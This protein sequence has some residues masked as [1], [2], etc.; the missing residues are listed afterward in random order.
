MAR[1]AENRAR[2]AGGLTALGY[3]MPQGQTP[4]LP[5]LVGGAD[6]AVALSKNLLE[7]GVLAPAVR[8]PTVP[9]GTSRLRLTVMATHT[10]GQI[11]QALAAIEAC[12]G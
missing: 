9:E 7:R 5:V 6:D 8:P 3:G 10:E 11:D 2:L 4:I 12:R 1:L